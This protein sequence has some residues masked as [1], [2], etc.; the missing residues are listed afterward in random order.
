MPVAITAFYAG[1][2]ALIAI[3]LGV[4]V[5]LMRV[6]TGVSILHGNNMELAQ[7]IRRHANFT[8]AVPI[9]LILMGLI[10]LDGASRTL[11]HSLGAALVVTRIA[12]PI[13]LTHDNLRSP[14]RGVGA[15]G[16]TLITLVAAIVAIWQFL[17][18]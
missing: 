8:E 5:G 6:K 9:A 1:I 11:L 2:L 17:G 7:V 4:Q 12:H 16:T 3:V 15:L 18:A 13:G 10:E 14:L